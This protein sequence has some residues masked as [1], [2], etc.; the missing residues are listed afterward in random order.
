MPN[1][2]I[3]SESPTVEYATNTFKN[4]PV[5]L[6]YD[7]TPLIEVV[8]EQDAGFTSQFRIC[9]KDGVYIAKARGSRLFLTE[10]GKKMNLKPRT[11]GEVV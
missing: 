1:K 3:F 8:Q 7:E 9:N 11:I 4:V 10:D 6:Q 2:L 5:I